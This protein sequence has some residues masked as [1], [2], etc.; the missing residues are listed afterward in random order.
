M[1]VDLKMIFLLCDETH[2]Q[3]HTEM[4]KP[5]LKMRQL[6]FGCTRFF[7][8]H[9]TAQLVPLIKPKI[10]EVEIQRSTAAYN[11]ITI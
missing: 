5:F 6:S 7:T 3:N 11:Q 9:V 10:G 1:H 8:H 4:T 2:I